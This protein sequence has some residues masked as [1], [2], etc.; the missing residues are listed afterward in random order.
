MK[1]AQGMD[2]IKWLHRGIHIIFFHEFGPSMP[3]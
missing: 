3:Q 1:K 2:E